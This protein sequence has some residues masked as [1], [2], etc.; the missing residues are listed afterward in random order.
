MNRQRHLQR[1][2]RGVASLIVVMVLFFI[3]SLVAAYAS[4]NQIFEQRT[5]ANQYRSMQALEAAEAGLEWALAQLNA[6]RITDQC[7]P[8][9][10]PSTEL[11]FRDR[12]LNFDPG[13]G[14]ITQRRGPTN[15]D[16]LFPT[17][18][19]DGGDWSCSC[20]SDGAPS[21]NPP[22]SAGPHAAFRLFFKTMA[23]PGL[24]QVLANACTKLDDSCL[25]FNTA[26]Y[27]SQIGATNE[28]AASVSVVLSIAG[29]PSSPPLA[30]LTVRGSVGLS[31]AARVYNT[32]ST[33]GGLT[34][35]SGG[36]ITAPLL[37]AGTLPGTPGGGL[38]PNDTV[39]SPNTFTS[40]RMF[41]AVFNMWR[42]TYQEQPAALAINCA[43]GSCTAQ[44]IRDAAAMNP[45]RPMWVN[46]GLT[47]DTPG[48]IG[49]AAAPVLVT[50]NGDLSFGSAG[51]TL[52]GL[53]FVRS[54]LWTVGGTSGT[55]RGALVA[56]GDVIGAG[57]P[58]VI[59]DAD[60]LN[61]LRTYTG[62]FVRVPG[63]WKDYP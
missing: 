31:G 53:V 29:G 18:V 3:V 26:G 54:D 1:P 52:Y 4:R 28:G 15:A 40:A 45:G 60:V 57:T 36:A 41:P 37:V 24:V 19:F 27:S 63:T 2:A 43:A 16:Y 56:D 23:Q 17:C 21:L 44:Q 8:S 7:L 32:D 48:D 61:H 47:L 13:T 25:Q 35:Q 51:A 38:A 55:L 11:A 58:T 9:A 14:L 49:S 46:G 10:S 22:T 5:S 42:E 30:A 59:Y 12:Y 39:M 6:G 33:S 20:P 50:V 34:I 62:S